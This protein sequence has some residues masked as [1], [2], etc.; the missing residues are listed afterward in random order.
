ME[1]LLLLGILT[2]AYAM[3][4]AK[5]M[6]ALIA[7]FRLQSLLLFIM[8]FMEALA[9][10]SF[11]LYLVAALI[12]ALKVFLIPLALFR[13]LKRL[14][15]DEHVGFFINPLLSLAI[16]LGLTYLAWVFVRQLFPDSAIGFVLAAAISFAVMQV[17]AMI[18]VARIKAVTQIIGLMV[19]ENGI[20]LL[21]ST[22]TGGLSLVVEMAVFLDVFIS[23]I[24]LGVFV[25][26][27]NE[28]FTG[29]D[30]DQLKGLRG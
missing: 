13:M 2:T 10:G 15:V 22:V 29:I 19:I 9:H 12:L 4:T 27:I 23:V 11:N 25:Y 21:A 30:V 18:M 1:L 20:F 6:S 5:R 17:G 24:I 7:N 28:L 3:L 16:S 14:K 26:R 8:T